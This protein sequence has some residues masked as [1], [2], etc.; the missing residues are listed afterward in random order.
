MEAAENVVNL[1]V[2]VVMG[3]AMTTTHVTPRLVATGEEP[4]I[5]LALVHTRPPLLDGTN[6]AYWKAKMKIYI[7]AQDERAWRSVED[8]W[9]P[10]TAEVGKGADKKRV[11]KPSSEWNV[12]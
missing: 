9:I 5:L 1:R 8:G 12:E 4:P 11:L 7:K 2:V 3:V 10:P 6:Y